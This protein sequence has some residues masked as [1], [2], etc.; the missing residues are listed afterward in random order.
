MKLMSRRLPLIGN[1]VTFNTTRTGEIPGLGLRDTATTTIVALVFTNLCKEKQNEEKRSLQDEIEA[2]A[3][4]SS[5]SMNGSREFT[6]NSTRDIC[7]LQEK[8]SK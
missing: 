7:A 1:A 8:I 5:I 6:I 4:K 3:D 2:L